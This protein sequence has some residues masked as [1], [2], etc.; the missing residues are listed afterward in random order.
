MELIHT[1]KAEVVDLTQSTSPR[2]DKRQKRS[3][4]FSSSGIKKTPTPTQLETNFE[5]E[6]IKLDYE[7]ELRK[8]ELEV[9]FRERGLER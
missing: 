2:V 3:G 4:G 7:F 9:K 1:T 5:Q 6:R 8:L